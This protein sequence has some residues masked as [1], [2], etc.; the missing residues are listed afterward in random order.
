[1]GEP[2][3]LDDFLKWQAPP[4][5]PIVDKGVMYEG[6]KIILYGKYKTMKSML[7]IRFALSV[8]F[9][10]DWLGFATTSS[11]KN[12]LYLQLEIPAPLL[13][14]RLQ[15]MK[16]TPT[17]KLI[18]WTEHNI[19]IDTNEGMAKI[20]EAI[21]DFNIEILILDP[22]YKVMSGNLIENH[23]VKIFTDRVDS[24]MAKY[25]PLSVLLISHSR[26][27]QYEE[28]WGSDDLIGGSFFSNWADGIIGIE[29]ISQTRLKAHFDVM[30]NAEDEILPRVLTV[31]D[32]IDFEWEMGTIV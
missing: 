5:V 30:R 26:K 9:G 28:A 17:D 18:I 15:A 19:A 6:S 31:T 29:R 10:V 1:M 32:D 7:A 4:L 11:G 27:G 2:Q 20:E 16:A 14:R 21:E 22:I 13:Q 3:Y 25:S 8:A 23:Q 24:L 12:I